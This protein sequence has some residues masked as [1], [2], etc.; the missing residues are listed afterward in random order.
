MT[1][2]ALLYR[3]G[4]WLLVPLA[5]GGHG[6]GRAARIDGEGAILGYFFG[7]RLSR[8]P[9]FAFLEQLRPQDA[10]MIKRF[11]DLGIQRGDWGVIDGSDNWRAENWP[12]PAF[13]QES[14]LDHRCWRVTYTADNLLIFSER[15]E[16]PCEEVRHLNEDGLSG[17][18]ALAVALDRKVDPT[19][20]GPARPPER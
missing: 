20:S 16:R 6:L 18:E 1:R 12:I 7:P 13:R 4:D 11:G 15:V 5:S 3:E 10:V 17:S 8:P 14:L 19:P 9:D 2:K